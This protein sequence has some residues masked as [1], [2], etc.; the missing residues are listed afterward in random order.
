[1]N[2]VGLGGL[3]DFSTGSWKIYAAQGCTKVPGSSKL[4]KNRE[5]SKGW[6]LPKNT[7]NV[8]IRQ[9]TKSPGFFVLP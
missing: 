3:Y 9:F 1:M 6:Y 5:F 8:N 7:E 4:W 2:G